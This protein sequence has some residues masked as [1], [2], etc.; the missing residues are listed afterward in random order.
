MD[1]EQ[2]R[3]YEATDAEGKFA[4]P[5]S[6]SHAQDDSGHKI[7]LKNLHVLVSHEDGVWIAQGLEID[8]VAEGGSFEEV[9]AAFV[10]GMERTIDE[11]LR[12]FNTIESLLVPAP[13]DTWQPYLSA[14]PGC[15]RMIYQQ[16]S[17]HKALRFDQIDYVELPKAA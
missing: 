17:F 16:E 9:Q 8:Y 12:R 2:V 11:N 14:E 5:A 7:V 1:N 4:P 13:M 15:L 6:V 10:K 3:K